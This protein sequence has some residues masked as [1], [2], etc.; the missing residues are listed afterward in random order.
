MDH[1]S[2]GTLTEP[3]LRT[4]QPYALLSFPDLPFTVLVILMPYCMPIHKQLPSH[5]PCFSSHHTH[6]SFRFPCLEV[7]YAALFRAQVG[8]NSFVSYWFTPFLREAQ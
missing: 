2:L 4:L 8:Y 5:L 3:S 6:F 1:T 7:V